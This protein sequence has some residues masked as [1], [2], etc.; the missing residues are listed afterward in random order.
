MCGDAAITRE[1]GRSQ[2][3]PCPLSSPAAGRRHLRP[4]P[5]WEPGRFR[6]VT[7]GGRDAEGKESGGECWAPGGRRGAELEVGG[8]RFLREDARST[9]WPSLPGNEAAG[10]GDRR[11]CVPRLPGVLW[12]DRGDLV[13]GVTAGARPPRASVSVKFGMLVHG[14]VPPASSP[15]RGGSPVLAPQRENSGSLGRSKGASREVAESLPQFCRTY[16]FP[17]ILNTTQFVR[18]RDN[19]ENAS[20]THKH[21]VWRI[22]TCLY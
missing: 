22:G 6:C 9:V 21:T 13:R 20:H 12:R 2:G 17:N 3:S 14:T 11:L 8:L 1:S 4:P 5:P 10:S 19:L 16:S 15:I 18:C 7:S